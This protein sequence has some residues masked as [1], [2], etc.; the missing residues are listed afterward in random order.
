MCI[1]DSYTISQL[2]GHLRKT[3]LVNSPSITFEVTQPACIS[4]P[5]YCNITDSRNVAYLS[6]PSKNVAFQEIFYEHAYLIPA[7]S[8][9][10]LRLLYSNFETVLSLNG[11]RYDNDDNEADRTI[12]LGL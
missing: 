2:M 8:C 12:M 11:I 9:F 4:P 1:R 5:S 3:I 6:P 7:A 10:Q